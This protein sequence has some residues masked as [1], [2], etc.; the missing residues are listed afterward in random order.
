MTNEEAIQFLD[1]IKHEEAGRAIGKDGFYAELMGYHVEALNMAIKALETIPKYKDAYNK[2]WDDGAK[3]TYEHL[4]MCEEEQGGDLISRDAVL[5]IIHLFF[6]EEVDKIPTKKTEDGEVLVIHKCQPLFEMN[7]AI[8]KR[9]KA[10]PSVSPTQNCVGN[11][12]DMRCDDAISRQAVLEMAYDMSEIDGEHFTEPCIVVDVE[13][14]QNLPPVNP[15]EP[16]AGHCKDCKYFE[17]DSVAKV[18]GIPLIVAHEI[19]SKWGN[20]CKTREDGYCFL[21]EPQESEG[22]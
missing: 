9:I 19:C 17:Y 5:D 2:G 21:F 3:A 14:I 16:K 20:G 22:V 12:L 6:T 4:K 7:K 8:C 15:Q 13:D 18:D 1:N 10:L 11:A